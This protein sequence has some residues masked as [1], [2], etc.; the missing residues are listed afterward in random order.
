MGCGGGGGGV[1]G[2]P[3][4]VAYKMEKSPIRAGMLTI[5]VDSSGPRA[6]TPPASVPCEV[7]SR[8]CARLSD[9]ADRRTT[10]QST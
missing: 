6:A 4:V 2:D 7:G 3:A 5:K 9:V 1:N 10:G 8:V